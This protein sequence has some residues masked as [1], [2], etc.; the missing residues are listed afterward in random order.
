MS[1][2][3]AIPR[4]RI[5]IY[6]A[7]VI[8]LLL[9]VVAGPTQAAWGQASSSSVNGVVTDQVG[10]VVSGA[11][12]T[13]K[14]TGTNVVRETVTNASGAYVFTSVPPAGY[15]LIFTAPT[16]QTQTVAA[17]DVAVAQAVTINATLRTGS[18]SES[19][20]VEAAGTQVESSTAQLGTVIDEKAVNNLPLN[21]RNFTQLLTLT[22]GVTPISTGQNSSAS[23]TAVTAASTTAYS[24]PSINGAG[25]RSTIYL[26]DGMNDN[27]AWYNT[28]AVPPIVDTIQEFKIN[29]HNDALYG[30]SLGGVV[31]VAT[32]SGTNNFHGSAWEFLRNNSFDAKPYIAAPGSYHLNTFGGQVSGP[33]SV[34]HFYDGRN[35]TFFLVG[36]EVTHYSKA[37]SN[38][39]LIPTQAQLNGD[40]S[41]ATTGVNKGG[42]CVAGDTVARTYACQLYDPT[43]ANS[44]ATPSR[45]AFLGNQ[46][47]VAKLNPYALAY[48][49][50]V[51]G[52]ATPIVIPGIAPTQYNYQITE[53]TRQKVYNYTGRIDQHLGTRDFIFFR[54]SGI[55]WNQ[56]S[57]STLPTLFTSTDIPA[58]QYG[59]SWMHVFSPT[60]S[61]QVQYGRT[62][63]EDNVITQFNDHNLWQKYGCSTDMC[64]SFVGGATVLVAQNVTGGF[65]GG[66]SNSPSKNLSS[67][68]EW[69]GSVMR[70]IGNHQVQAGGGWDQVNY[71]AILRQGTVGFTGASTSNFSG[72][73]GS[74]LGMNAAQ[75]SA[76]SGFGLADFLLGYPNNENK[77]NVFLTERPG[78][79]AN[80]YLQDS[81]KATRNLTLNYGVRYDRSVIPAFGTDESIGLQGS[82]ETGDFDF[83][84]G[85]YVIQKLPPLCSDRKHAPCLPSA[86]LPA[87][88]RVATGGKILHGSKDNVSP[89]FGFAYRV[90]D[91][92]SIR[93]GYGI[94]YDNWAAIIQMTQNY[95]GSWPD[96]GT[97][98]INGT[99]TPGT[100]YTSAQNPFA[101]NAGNLP[102]A[103]P[104]GSSNVNYMVDPNW[105]NPYS[106]QYNAGIEQ[107]FGDRTVLSLNYVGSQSRRMDIG[108]YYNTGTPCAT[109]ASFAARGTNTGQPFPYTVPQKSWDHSGGTASYNALQASLARR[110]STGLGYTVAYTWSKTLNDGTDGYF[111]VE[112]GVPED[113]YNPRGSRG[114]ASFSI[115]QILTANVI[116]ELPFGKNKRFASGSSLV[117]Y[118]IGNWQVNTIFS[119]RSGQALNITAAGD[120]ANTGNAGTYE[121]ADLVGDP[122]VAGAVASNPSCS[123]PIGNTRTR[124]QWFNPCAFKAPAIG[125]LGNAPRNFIRGPEFWN[126]DASVHRTFPIHEGIGFKID[127]EAFNAFNHPVLGNPASSVTTPATFGTITSVASGNNARIL[128]F[129]G[130]FQF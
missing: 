43:V 124:G 108:G 4:R 65:S 63:V 117:N 20:T 85:D 7:F 94:T 23:N 26:V 38:N 33:V 50:A 62:H 21:G 24:F 109:C 91:R 67:I 32:K 44:A 125:T 112:G 37:G 9:A 58:Q 128:Q 29:S 115:P 89:R 3:F 49:K 98:Q 107:Q 114:P 77:R 99:N 97:L 121:R 15:T 39:I 66:E 57:P 113:P 18:V 92:M 64:A 10:A 103:T 16:F 52:N 22:P 69:M 48:V 119:A 88:V 82:I 6:L 34:P 70:T 116:Y 17:F 36:V 123:A 126:V 127:V 60:T 47:P 40:F 53:A 55:Q 106:H 5:S 83:N 28:Y 72:N 30:G 110:F 75:I 90:N 130:K 129:A 11:K 35:K 87:H 100:P 95:Q 78:G 25:N 45:P 102:A 74:A 81:W 79:I 54:Y 122:F 1:G 104:F 12:V 41:S 111:G 118:I 14:N 2:H 93:G 61:M 19:V 68:H 105:K 51:F 46:I 120:I 42:T 71:T 59:V 27:Q 86:T 76:Q 84:T 101:N 56:D 96:T 73:P 13:L 8:A 80:V 31:N